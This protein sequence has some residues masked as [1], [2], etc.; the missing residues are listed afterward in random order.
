MP[1]LKEQ[2]NQIKAEMQAIV[3]RSRAA[4]RDLTSAEAQ[5]IED[6]AVKHEELTGRAKAAE[7]AQRTVAE[8]AGAPATLED[9]LAAG[10]T[11]G[12]SVVSNMERVAGGAGLK[13]ILNGQ[14]NTP[15]AVEVAAL[16]ASPTRLLD[17][18]QR[19]RLDSATFAFLRQT[20]AENNAAVVADG[21]TKPTSTYTFEEIEDRARVIAHLSEPFPLRYLDDHSSMTQVL[22]EQMRRGVVSAL[23]AQVVSGTGTGEEF[24]GLLNMTGVT[25]VPF[26]GDVVT[27]VRRAVTVLQGKDE[28]PTAWVFN[29]V[30]AEAISLTREDGESGGFLFGDDYASAAVF[31][32]VGTGVV[33]R[34]LPQGTA[35][36]ADWSQVRVMV[37]ET[38]HTLAATQAGDLFDKNQVKLRAEGRYG[39]KVFRPQAVAVVHLTE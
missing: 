19:E 39:L 29:P 13:N 3:D 36:L 35:L 8:L 10:K 37:R 32:G 38:E 9:T 20:A 34:A 18:I 30:D 23:E 21:E 11:W 4:N 17:L 5:E 12:K 22:D 24:T 15:P 1:T 31:G 16:P 7:Q 14:V 6:L 33:S 26:A 28:V 2:A 25:D 27:T